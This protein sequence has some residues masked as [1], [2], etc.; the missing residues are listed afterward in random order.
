MGARDGPVRFDGGVLQNFG[1]ILPGRLAGMGFP[2]PGAGA[3]LARPGVAAVLSLTDHAPLDDLAGAGLVVRREPIVDFTAPTPDV[4]D[5]CLAFVH[6]RWAAGQAVVV[7]CVA[8]RGRTGTVLAAVL[9]DTGLSP[10][11]AVARIR[12][13]RPGSLETEEQEAAVHAFAARR[14]KEAR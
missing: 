3:E 14:R 11:E 9:V 4:L 6:E 12:R 13:E 7:H 5:R 10:T 8:G 2:R 1:W